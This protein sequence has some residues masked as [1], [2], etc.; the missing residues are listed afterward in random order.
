MKKII[1]LLSI[2]LLFSSCE[3]TDILVKT[4]QMEITDLN[5]P[6]L[7]D[8]FN[9]E[10]WL[11]VDASYVSVGKFNNDSIQNNRARFSNIE[12]NDLADAQSFAITV[13]NSGSPAPSNYVL[14]V[15]NFNGNTANLTVDAELSN[16]VLPLAKRITGSFTVQTATIPHE[17][18]ENY[19][20]N[21]IWFFKGS[22]NARETT[23][24][25][26]YEDLQ[27]QAWVRKPYENTYYDLNMGVITSDTLSD[28]WKGF[29][30]PSYQNNTPKFAGEDFLQQPSTGTT[31]PLNYFPLDVR[32]SEV[33]ITPIL[34][35]YNNPTNP[36][37]ITLLKGF[38]PEGIGNDTNQTYPLEINTHFGA[39][40][41]KL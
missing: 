7:P 29:T 10:A 35:N 26:E 31:Y 12:V 22:G 18:L 1:A 37:P 9:Y 16:G 23:I 5:L 13:E 34:P 3:E 17:D 39:K 19:G 4:G 38:V 11:L 15:G 21:G 14:L 30:L 36:F 40:A 2:S 27:Y 28:N 41:V 25:F 32:G 20:V 8:G 24:H 33:L 6:L